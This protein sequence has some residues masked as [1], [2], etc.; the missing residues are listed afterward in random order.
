MTMPADP[1]ETYVDCCRQAF[2]R[3]ANRNRATTHNP[4]GMFLFGFVDEHLD[5]FRAAVP[6][7][8]RQTGRPF[9][10]VDCAGKTLLAVYTEI[11]T[12]LG[13][14]APESRDRYS[15][16]KALEAA[17]FN[18]A[19]TIVVNRLS[20][21]KASRRLT[22]AVARHLVK[23]LDDAHYRDVRAFGDV[24]FI[25]RASF[26]ERGWDW[27]GPYLQLVGPPDPLREFLD[28]RSSGPGG[29]PWL[30]PV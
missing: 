24:L 15:A 17:L 23:I 6:V 8:L 5:A 19:H 22:A 21:L 18:T 25:D 16:G 9:T 30:T 10:I 14:P 28:K 4:D 1:N 3:L 2:L 20:E 11:I 13:Q 7:A 26:L 27:F 12:G 29:R